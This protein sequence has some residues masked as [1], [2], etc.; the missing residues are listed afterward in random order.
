[1]SQN[2]N[3]KMEVVCIPSYYEQN[4]IVTSMN[5]CDNDDKPPNSTR[6]EKIP[7]FQVNQVGTE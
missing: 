7:L 3:F 2:R 5:D 4:F 1:M 6:Q